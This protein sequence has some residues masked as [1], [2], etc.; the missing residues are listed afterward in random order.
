MDTPEPLFEIY[1]PPDEVTVDFTEE[2]IDALDELA[3]FLELDRTQTLRQAL[4]LYQLEVYNRS[5]GAQA[6][7]I[8]SA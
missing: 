7:E 2:E 1:L 4:R 8:T 5:G 6:R 3:E